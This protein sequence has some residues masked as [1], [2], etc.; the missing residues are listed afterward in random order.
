MKQGSQKEQLV[1]V[2]GDLLS[3]KSS[4]FLTGL[5]KQDVVNVG[6]EVR[7]Q[8]HEN[9]PKCAAELLFRPEQSAFQGKGLS[10]DTV[11]CPQTNNLGGRF[12]HG[13]RMGVI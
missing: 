12:Q 6:L 4:E 3:Y 13:T 1:V 10:G 7:E 5:M 11:L 2:V 8:I 9:T